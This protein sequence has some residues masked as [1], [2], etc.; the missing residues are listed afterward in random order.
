[1]FLKKL[2][3]ATRAELKSPK[4]LAL[5]YIRKEKRTEILSRAGTYQ[6]MLGLEWVHWT[7]HTQKEDKS[8]I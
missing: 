4:L 3:G 5:V 7:Q 6:E 1:M 8:N 2:Q